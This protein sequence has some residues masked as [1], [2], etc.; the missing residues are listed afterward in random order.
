MARRKKAVT[1][2]I[3]EMKAQIELAKDPNI[4]VFTPLGG[5][6]P[7][8][9]VIEKNK[10]VSI[11]N[12]GNPG[13]PINPSRRPKA[14]AGD[15]ELDVSGQYLL[16]GFIDMHAHIGGSDQGTTPEYVFKLW[17]AHGITSI[18]EPGSFNGLD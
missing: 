10:I 18:R 1:G 15:K 12:V 6:G 16:P 17:M 5:L 8:D 14:K 4:L 13:V 2:L 3:S 9:I 11:H 7:V